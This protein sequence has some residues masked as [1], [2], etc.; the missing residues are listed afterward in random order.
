MDN[1]TAYYDTTQLPAGELAQ[2]RRSATSQED[3]VLTFFRDNPYKLFTPCQVLRGAFG[4]D[5]P[6]TSVRRAMAN[7]TS[8]GQLNKTDIQRKDHYGRKAHCWQLAGKPAQADMFSD[9]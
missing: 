5:T 7:L 1:T 3:Q 8:R 2:A 4:I 6:I 9:V